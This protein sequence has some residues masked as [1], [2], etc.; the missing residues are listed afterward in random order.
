ML[1]IPQT[2]ALHLVDVKD[3]TY[4]ISTEESLVD[5]IASIR[6]IGLLSPP[7]LKK[8]SR[9]YTIISGFKRVRACVNLGWSTIEARVVN[10]ELSDLQCVKLAIADNL[11]NR[12]LNFIE[13]SISIF[14]LSKYYNDEA[15]IREAQGLGLNI[16]A[17]LLKK[18]KKIILLSPEL[19]KSILTGTIPLTIALEL[20]KMDKASAMALSQ[21]F[22]L[23]KPTFSHQ[24]EI[25]AMVKTDEPVKSAPV[26]TKAVPAVKAK[27]KAKSGAKA[28]F[29]PSKIA[30]AALAQLALEENS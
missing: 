23:L 7:I 28:R 5:L 4:K 15:V 14:I 21:L 19:K 24:K 20:G 26:K 27:P 6:H 10:S 16:N 25:L 11:V 9:T 29:K 3:T 17:S 2:I 13:Q 1:F 30:A 22:E 12:P 8:K 18:L